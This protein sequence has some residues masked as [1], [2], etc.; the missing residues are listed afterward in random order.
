MKRII[1]AIVSLG[2]LVALLLAVDLRTLAGTFRTTQWGWFAVAI[3]MFVPQ[4]LVIS[5][6]WRRLVGVLAPISLGEAVSLILA[7][8]TMNLVLPSKMGDLTKALFLKRT[9]TLDLK[10]A[11]NV[12]VF[13]KMLDVAVLAGVMVVGVALLLACHALQPAQV[14]GALLA[15][16]MGL[17]AVFLV[18]AA[19]FIP[20]AMIPGFAR[21]RA[22]LGRGRKLGK[23]AAFLDS[24]HDVISLLQSRGARRGRVL[25]MSLLIWALHLVQIW[26]FFRSVGVN[27]PLTQFASMVPLAIFIGIV[28]VTIGGF[29]TRDAA[30]VYLFS[31]YPK[32]AMLAAALYVDLRYILPSI[33]GIPFLNRYILWESEKAAQ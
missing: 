30:M 28:P 32:E 6:R 10:R 5:M 7:S 8:Q 9:G 1:A 12:V 3:L 25:A 14:G 27:P 33:A 21:A 19:Y 16:G 2:V 23:L 26:F 18:A 20:P 22:F 17:C 29:G 15:G 4:V 31:Q 11:T 24:G 13:E